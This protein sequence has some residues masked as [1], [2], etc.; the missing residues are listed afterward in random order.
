MKPLSGLPNGSL[1]VTVPLETAVIR[2]NRDLI[3][4]V[5]HTMTEGIVVEMDVRKGNWQRKLGLPKG[6]NVYWTDIR[7]IDIRELSVLPWPISYRLTHG[8]GWYRGRD[9]KKVYFGIQQHLE[10]IDLERQCSKTTI[11]AAVLLCI[12]GGIGFQCVSWMMK[13]LFHC[14][15]SKSA[16]DRW[17]RTCSKDLPDQKGMAQAL[18]A[19]KRISECHIDE[20]FGT[21]RRPKAC[22]VVL[23]DEHGRIF[24]ARE[25]EQK[26]R[27]EVE[28][29]L[30][31]VK[32]WGLQITQF[33][34]DGCQE[35]RDAARIVFP[36][37]T[38]QY[39]YF[40]IIQNIWKKLWR[41]MVGRRRRIKERGEE[42]K[43]NHE[44]GWNSWANLAQRI[45]ENRY[46]V[47]KG[48]AKLSE[49]EKE[50]LEKL[51][52]EEAVIEK[53]RR[54]AKGVWSI[55]QDSKTEE[56]AKEKLLELRYRPEVIKGSV[57]MKA[58]EFLESRF[59]DMVTYIRQPGVKRN[60]YSESG[61][62]CLRRLEQG[63]DG[64]R[65]KEGLDRYLR[66]YQAIRYLD[67]TVHRGNPGLGLPSS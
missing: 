1:S 10:E 39:D 6:T 8:D 55:F 50:T 48:E 38:I 13:L 66:L 9:S 59:E 60:S 54:F 41:E 35:Y 16:L 24:A 49:Q 64:F 44:P 21:G 52:E 20:Y 23:K 19:D 5:H 29:F 43:K 15:I 7:P 28:K 22:T 65:S 51:M 18:N 31:E 57:Y 45:W 46:I 33:Y 47:L 58:V 12:L 37:A 40:H 62:R 3:T 61:M 27:D 2:K 11:R 4:Q 63:H 34:M 32:E 25:M 56:Q 36:G 42:Q 17:V 67:W 26:T 30:Q 14:E 53:I